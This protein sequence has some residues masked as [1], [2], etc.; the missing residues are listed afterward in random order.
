MATACKNRCGKNVH[1]VQMFTRS[2]QRALAH[3]V[4]K[5]AYK[6]AYIYSIYNTHCVLGGLF[7]RSLV[8][9][10]CTQLMHTWL[11]S[12]Q[13][14]SPLGFLASRV[15]EG[16]GRTDKR[17]MTILRIHRDIC[18]IGLPVANRSDNC[19]R[20]VMPKLSQG[21]HSALCIF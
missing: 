6:R 8:T 17:T 16:H 15:I 3:L 20:V 1:T 10:Y 19:I 11:A 12:F 4:F 13:Y 14:S 5:P 18:L 21:C 7:S 2:T 9:V